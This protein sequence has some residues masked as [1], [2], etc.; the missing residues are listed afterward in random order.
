MPYDK[1]GNRNGYVLTARFCAEIRT[2]LRLIFSRNF[3][4][5]LITEYRS[6]LNVGQSLPGKINLN[7]V[8]T[9]NPITFNMG[10]TSKKTVFILVILFI[11]LGGKTSAQVKID[12]STPM[13]ESEKKKVPFDEFF[14]LEVTAPELDNIIKLKYEPTAGNKRDTRYFEKVSEHYI[15][16]EKTPS[17]VIF[18][19]IR[20]RPSTQYQF[21]FFSLSEI[22]T[23]EVEQEIKQ[24]LIKSFN[25]PSAYD[26]TKHLETTLRIN[27]ALRIFLLNLGGEIYD[28]DGKKVN[29]SNE[30]LG[31]RLKVFSGS[32]LQYSND[33]LRI[34]NKESQALKYFDKNKSEKNSSYYSR[35]ENVK[36]TIGFLYNDATLNEKEKEFL[37][38]YKEWLSQNPNE[39]Q[40]IEKMKAFLKKQKIDNKELLDTNQQLIVVEEGSFSTQRS[41][42]ENEMK[43]LKEIVSQFYQLFGNVADI[44]ENETEYVALKQSEASILEN[45]NISIPIYRQYIY[46][47]VDLETSNSPYLGFEIGGGLEPFSDINKFN[48]IRALN[49]YF[50]PVNKN[51]PLSEFRFFPKLLKSVGVQLGLSKSL[52]GTENDRY[53]NYLRN[54]SGLTGIGVRVLKVFR[55]NYGVVWYKLNDINP[56]VDSSKFRPYPYITFSINAGLVDTLKTLSDIFD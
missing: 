30:D 51:V 20:L 55:V 44:I 19:S 13:K 38:F 37:A 10:I 9:L 35:I 11:C 36:K 16:G 26:S 29:L 14:D 33:L 7:K 46:S 5:W 39:L 49:I 25:N 32:L 52:L 27:K 8:P 43:D 12:L 48:Y 56:I 45:F 2:S 17:S 21:S 53:T 4:S 42:S 22:E 3:K 18:R 28:S 47:Y 15:Q 34:T 1:T 31:K 6:S 23:D 41:I 54:S 50:S 40:E 24:I